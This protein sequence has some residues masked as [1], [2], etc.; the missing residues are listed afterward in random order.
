MN[1]NDSHQLEISDLDR[2]KAEN[3]ELRA[4]LEDAYS[5][6]KHFERTIDYSHEWVW[7]VDA[8]GIYTYAS[9]G[10]ENTLGFKPEE[11]IGKT[12]FD[13]MPKEEA[14]RVGNIFLEIVKEEQSF[15]RLLNICLHK[16][17]QEVFSETSGKPFYDKDGLF[18]GYRG[19]DNDRTEHISEENLLKTKAQELQTALQHQGQ[20]ILNVTNSISDL[21]FYKDPELRYIGCNQAFS[22]FLGL[23]IDYIIGK[24]DFEL[25]PPEY[26]ELFRSKDIPV[27]E[28]L[29]AYSNHEWVEHADG[30]SLYLLT[31]KSPLIDKGGLLLG[32][33]GISRDI[34]EEYS[35]KDDIKEA[36][37]HLIDAQKIAKVGH[38]KWNIQTGKLAW[39]DEIYR[40]FGFE[41]Q[42]FEPTYEAF[43]NTIHP[44]DREMVSDA[45]NLAV[46][47][48]DEYN[49][50]HRIILPDGQQKVVHEI[51]HAAYDADNTPLRMIG[52]VHDITHIKKMESKLAEQEETFEFLFEHSADAIVLIDKD[53]FIDCN[54]ATVT[55][56]K[57]K[58]KGSVL[59]MHPSDI[60]PQFQ[61]DGQSSYD[62]AQKMMGICL[63]KGSNRFDWVHLNSEGEE[64]WV[65]VILTRIIING[66]NIIHGAMRDIADQ[67]EL[68]N[69]LEMT[70]L[71]YKDLAARLDL[72]VKEQSTQ[73]VKQSRMAQMGELLSMIAHQWR[74]PLSS[75]A[76]VSSSIKLKIDLGQMN[77]DSEEELQSFQDYAYKQ[78][79]EVEGY[80]NALSST[81][82]DFRTLYK[83]DKTMHS[84][85]ITE[86][87]KSALQLVERSFREHSVL[88]EE[89]YEIDLHVPMHNNEVMQVIL[90]L[91]KNAEDNFVEKGTKDPI[92]SVRTVLLEKSVKI[93]ISDNGGGIEESILD[94]IFDPYFSTKN[95]KN[96]TG[97]GLYMCKIIIEEHQKGKL[98]VTNTEIGACFT[99]ELPLV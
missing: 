94:K 56:L 39:S 67:K 88:V 84:H 23:P 83:P 5:I 8:N 14:E 42:E 37:Q 69:E 55:M 71:R 16:D 82:D 92:V 93:E 29:Q 53:K 63:E 21:I 58:D 13:F 31:Q 50:F 99:I 27:L 40:V 81:I 86:P 38:W 61:P 33:V 52:I 18:S 3:Q 20:L 43:L 80:V 26:A 11:L 36:H 73:L 48:Y 15:S 28:D 17:G 19:V 7:E 90:N 78:M 54:Q 98:Q 4:K 66:N 97:L 59:S 60:S 95:E 2:L 25:F 47:N 34:T 64:F 32:M 9:S 75:I 35:L 6:S 77:F 46:E 10:V 76:A 89:S 49:I 44:D 65:D 45:V 22:N 51:G 70:T 30:R 24:N 79:N 68:E 96:G 12:P 1:N 87:I 91:L 72:R 85:A 57:T 62:K 74:Q 41:P